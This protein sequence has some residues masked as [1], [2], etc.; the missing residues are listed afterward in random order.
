M[1]VV[2]KFLPQSG[3]SVFHSQEFFRLHAGDARAF[4]FQWVKK[5]R[6]L[7]SIHFTDAG[8]GHYLSPRRGTFGG[9]F[10]DRAMQPKDLIDMLESVAGYLKAAGANQMT[11]ALTPE[12]HDP[13]AFALEFYTLSSYGCTVSRFDLDFGRLV[14]AAPFLDTVSS[15]VRRRNKDLKSVELLVDRPGSQLFA[16]VHDFIGVQHAAKGYSLSMSLDELGQ[17]ETL[18]PGRVQGYAVLHEGVTVACA[19]C[20]RIRDDMQHIFLMNSVSH[21]AAFNA[22]AIAVQRIYE[23]CQRDG[24]RKLS[25]GTSTVG[26]SANDG[27]I[28]FKRS[29]GFSESIKLSFHKHL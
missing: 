21:S 25:Y 14:D 23:D 28:N 26:S 19:V 10:I 15:D 8:D 13:V 16:T 5:G 18:F 3:A 27:L 2:D 22:V 1:L 6:S 4:Y 29:L 9:F 24:L 11:V 7:A 20:I 12:W 17:M